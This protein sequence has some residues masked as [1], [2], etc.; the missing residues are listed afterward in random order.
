MGKEESAGSDAGGFLLLLQFLPASP[1]ELAP[2]HYRYLSPAVCY[3]RLLTATCYLPRSGRDL[4][5][6][7]DDASAINFLTKP[8]S[9]FRTSFTSF[10]KASAVDFSIAP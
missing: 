10:F 9:I 4:R 8:V 7:D 6:A 5:G 1:T 2:L 3:L